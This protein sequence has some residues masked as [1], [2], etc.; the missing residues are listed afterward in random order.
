MVLEPWTSGEAPCSALTSLW[1]EMPEATVTGQRANVAPAAPPA[2]LRATVPGA[3][4]SCWMT[5]SRC[6]LAEQQGS[7]HDRKLWNKREASCRTSQPG[8]T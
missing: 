3:L 8:A 2:P 4:S 6:L 5:S 7:G 1:N